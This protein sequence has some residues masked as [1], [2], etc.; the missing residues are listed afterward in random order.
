MK[1]NLNE[2]SREVREN[3]KSKVFKGKILFLYKKFSSW[4]LF[5]FIH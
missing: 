1:L 2:G 3:Q 4:K 5:N